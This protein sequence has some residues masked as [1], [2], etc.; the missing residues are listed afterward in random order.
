[1]RRLKKYFTFWTVVSV[2]GLCCLFILLQWNSFN[3][4]FER[5]EGHYAY[6]AWIM[7]RGL[8]PYIHTFEMKPPLI[9][10][11]YL[12]A[13]LID[14]NSVW[15]VHLIAF[16]SLALTVILVGL[17]VHH[18]FGQRAGLIAM[19]FVA[20]MVMFPPLTP[21]AAN[22]EKFM[23]L[24]LMGLLTIY[25]FN[26]ER[27]GRWPWFWAAVCG[28]AAILYKPI[29]LP[30]VLFI[31]LVWSVENWR[32]ERSVRD[33]GLKIAYASAGALL[34]LI[35]VTGYFFARGGFPGFW[36]QTV[37]FNRYYI[38]S[39]GGQAFSFL[40][41]K[42]RN[43]VSCWPALFVL[44]IWLLIKRPPR[45]WFYLGLLAVA[46]ATIYSTPYGH[47]YILLMPLWAIVSALALDSLAGQIG[48]SFKRPEWAGKIAIV[49]MFV[50][51]GSML[52]PVRNWLFLSPAQ[53]TAKSYGIYNPFIEAPLV[54]KRVAE[55]TKPDDYVF[56]AGTEQ[57]ILYFA[58]RLKPMRF[59]SL[60]ELM[61]EHPRNLAYQQETI[62]SLELNTPEVI[63][64]VRSPLSWM[65]AKSS[66]ELIFNYL[67]QLLN[68][69]YR[70]VGGAIRQ[71]STAYWQEPLRRE[72][73]GNCTIMIFELKKKAIKGP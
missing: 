27:P 21:Y 59:S 69:R 46:L 62:H 42:L 54:A 25:V 43:F 73:S 38:A 11:P 22:T 68:A 36:E 49:L 45:A 19:W 44:L 41:A 18:E 51:L 37:E 3:A 64:W 65:A 67:D 16:L 33:A 8:V 35:L 26:R 50:I 10:L 2:I 6:G 71:G 61:L 17:T 63:V 30:A 66:P 23:I 48:S 53:V 57:E 34:T 12:L 47:Y 29:A 72:T 32:R 13:L 24:P 28:L 55:L 70:L 7:T 4:P 60:Y 15:P 52:W 58:K 39:S 1:M 9:F 56:I 31:F 40:F 14:P 5:D 20:P